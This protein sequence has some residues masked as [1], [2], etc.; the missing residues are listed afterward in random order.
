MTDRDIIDY[1]KHHI[2]EGETADYLTFEIFDSDADERQWF[3]ED[4][5][6]D[7]IQSMFDYSMTKTVIGIRPLRWDNTHSGWGWGGVK[8]Y[9]GNMCPIISYTLVL[10]QSSDYQTNISPML[11]KFLE[12][13]LKEG[14]IDKLAYPMGKPR[15]VRLVEYGNGCP[16]ALPPE[17]PWDALEGYLRE[18]EE[19]SNG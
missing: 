10:K 5:I 14:S 8:S 7:F 13:I 18:G 3:G 17:D 15:E 1:I 16:I 19:T 11:M 2:M 12:V 4:T 6:D 9:N